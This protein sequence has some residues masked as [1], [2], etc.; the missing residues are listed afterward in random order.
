MASAWSARTK[1]P[2]AAM[3]AAVEVIRKLGAQWPDRE[4]AVTMNRMRCKTPDGLT[5]T[6]VRVAELRARLGVAA[7]DAEGD[8]VRTISADA[9]AQRLGICVPSVH[10]L[11]RSGVLPATQLMPSAPWQIPVDALD[12]EQ[13][14][15]GLQQIA[16]RRPT[17]ALAALDGR[18]LRLPGL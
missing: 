5:W 17:K 12:T 18:M 3:T 4:L 10:R 7:F 6:T 1:P 13:V 11:I 16:A 2:A 15:I 14:R 8:R 9:A